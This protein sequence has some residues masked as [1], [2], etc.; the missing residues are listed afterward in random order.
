MANSYSFI[1]KAYNY[2][3]DRPDLNEFIKNFNE[4]SGFSFSDDERITYLYN[5]LEAEKDQSGAS[6]SI[7]LRA[8]QSILKGVK[9]LEYYKDKEY[10]I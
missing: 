3:N 2:I 8:C 7:S 6:F 5:E 4:P 9:T 1:E 10:R